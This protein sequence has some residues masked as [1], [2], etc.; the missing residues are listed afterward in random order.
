M[1]QN[2][3]E[4]CSLL[5]WPLLFLVL[6]VWDGACSHAKTLKSSRVLKLLFQDMFWE[7]LHLTN[8]CTHKHTHTGRWG[9]GERGLF[10]LSNF[11]TVVLGFTV[12]ASDLLWVNGD[13]LLLINNSITP[14]L[15]K[16]CEIRTFLFYFMHLKIALCSRTRPY[17]AHF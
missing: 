10:P 2:H 17:K 6:K 15:E 12:E 14:Y 4:D 8:K 5:V 13:K 3:L 16:L 11:M 9:R 7:L 1:Y